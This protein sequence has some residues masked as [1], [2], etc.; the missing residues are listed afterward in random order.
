MTESV[1]AKNGDDVTLTIDRDVQWYVKKVL[2]EA[3]SKYG[4]AW[5]IAW[6]RMSRAGR[7]SHWPIAMKYRLVPMRRR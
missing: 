5:A 3:E 1:A 2:K 4:A 6:C 7:F